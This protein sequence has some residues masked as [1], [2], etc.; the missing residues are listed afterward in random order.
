MLKIFG[1]TNAGVV[2]ALS[3]IRPTD[4]RRQTGSVLSRDSSLVCRACGY[5]R[6]VIYAYVRSATP[7][8]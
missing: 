8:G 3:R 4:R 6:P 7:S 1:T 5:T 2:A